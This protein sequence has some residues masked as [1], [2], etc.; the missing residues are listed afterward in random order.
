M[1]LVRLVVPENDSVFGV[2]LK[3]IRPCT[4]RIGVRARA[5]FSAPQLIPCEAFLLLV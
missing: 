4:E 1:G 3:R 2:F 5:C